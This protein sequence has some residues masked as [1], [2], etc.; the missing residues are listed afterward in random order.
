[1][2]SKRIHAYKQQRKEVTPQATQLQKK[3]ATCTKLQPTL[4][5]H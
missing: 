5:Q 2:Q 1:M 3:R 4:I